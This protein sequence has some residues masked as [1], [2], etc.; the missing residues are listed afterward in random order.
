M[1]QRD[2]HDFIFIFSF[3]SLLVA[4]FRGY[5]EAEQLCVLLNANETQPFVG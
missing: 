2:V 3:L 4:M 1:A 5:L